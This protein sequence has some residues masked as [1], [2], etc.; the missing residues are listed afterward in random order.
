MHATNQQQSD[1]VGS[2]SSNS[3]V[4]WWQTKIVTQ[5][6]L[7]SGILRINRMS[8]QKKAA[9]IKTNFYYK[10]NLQSVIPTHNVKQKVQPLQPM[11]KDN[12]SYHDVRKIL[13]PEN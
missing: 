11:H 12:K 7:L 2:R 10:S 8:S 6:W 9:P 13:S 5:F 1:T 4:G 3:L